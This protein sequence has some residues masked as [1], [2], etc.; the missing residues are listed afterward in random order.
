ME[1][2]NVPRVAI[3]PK[4]GEQLNKLLRKGWTVDKLLKAVEQLSSSSSSENEDEEEGQNGNK[5]VDKVE[6]MNKC[7][8]VMTAASPLP[9]SFDDEQY[10][11]SNKK[12]HH[13]HLD[14]PH[15]ND[16]SYGLAVPSHNSSAPLSKRSTYDDEMVFPNTATTSGCLKASPQPQTDSAPWMDVLSSTS[17]QPNS[18]VGVA[19]ARPP[20]TIAVGT[21]DSSLSDGQRDEH[22]GLNFV[23]YPSPKSSTPLTKNSL[24]KPRFVSFVQHDHSSALSED[25]HIKNEDDCRRI[26]PVGDGFHELQRYA[27]PDEISRDDMLPFSPPPM[28]NLNTTNEND[29]HHNHPEE[30]TVKINVTLFDGLQ[31]EVPFTSSFSFAPV[32]NNNKMNNVTINNI[33]KSSSNAVNPIES[34]TTSD[35]VPHFG[36]APE[37]R[38]M[39]FSFRR[40]EEEDDDVPDDGIDDDFDEFTVE[41]V[42]SRTA[43]DASLSSVA[44]QRSQEPLHQDSSPRTSSLSI[45][46]VEE[47]NGTG[48]VVSSQNATNSS[49]SG[50]RRRVSVDV[51]S[52]D[53][54]F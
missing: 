27:S 15:F 34:S 12:Q 32:Q 48:R 53:D 4:R 10:Q 37:D 13:L 16:R 47:E 8:N 51:A 9:E 29:Q 2:L 19:A 52:L 3:N 11:Q 35:N 22:F 25:E 43:N 17:Q 39:N 23:A 33:N 54:I 30:A 21:G 45:P 49:K 28:H 36:I 41:D 26:F 42:H 38:K 6:K 20:T 44:K 14:A 1:R 40:D 24:L 31:K 46:T 50:G 7:T 18:A 5:G